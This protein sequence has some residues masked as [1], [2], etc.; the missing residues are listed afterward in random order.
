MVSPSRR[1]QQQ[2]RNGDALRVSGRTAAGAAQLPSNPVHQWRGEA[3][4]AD[5]AA[6]RLRASRK[7][8]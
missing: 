6:R 3:K 2:G 4:A 7:D 8:D 1:H 5:A